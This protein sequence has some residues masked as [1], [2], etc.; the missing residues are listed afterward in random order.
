V[1]PATDDKVLAAWNG[2]AITAFARA[3][4]VLRRETDLAS[5]RAAADF[6]LERLV[7]QGR[8]RATW[9]DGRARLNAYLDDHAFLGRALVDLYEACFA[10]RYLEA[11]ADLG[12]TLVERFED[13]EG[14]GF[15]FTSDDHETL[16][17]RSRSMH[18]GA[19]PSGAGVA[20]ELLLRLAVHLDLPELKHSAERLLSAYRPAVS[21]M[22]SAYAAV[23]A[24]ADL[25]AGPGDTLAIVGAPDDAA[26]LALLGAARRR[27]RP[28]LAVQVGPASERLALLRGKSALA[29]RPTAHVCRNQACQAPTLSPD[30]LARQLDER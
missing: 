5:A 29:G 19:L 12:R 27:F 21:R 3:Y 13:R 4:Q 16:L 8:L 6:A 25:A 18:D 7:H 26:S 28:R 11:A 1:R 17:A 20:A 2:L 30:E 22:P 15:F 23:V 14:G 24:A 10:P 9:R